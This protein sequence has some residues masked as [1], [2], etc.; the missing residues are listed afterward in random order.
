MHQVVENVLH[1]PHLNAHF[2]AWS[3]VYLL[4]VVL[5]YG[6]PSVHT[7]DV[8]IEHHGFGVCKSMYCFGTRIS[9]MALFHRISLCVVCTH[10]CTQ[11]TMSSQVN[12]EHDE[13]HDLPSPQNI[14][15]PP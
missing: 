4:A 2:V 3:S 9:D 5:F 6:T 15:R 11:I 7:F 13:L 1:P 8:D 14:S 10:C 12:E